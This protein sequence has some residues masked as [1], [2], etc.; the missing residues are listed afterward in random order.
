[1]ST[2]APAVGR[3]TTGL[4][5]DV[6]DVL[7]SHGYERAPGRTLSASLP[8]LDDLLGELAATYEGRATEEVAGA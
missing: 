6:F 4:L 1:M 7:A 8:L 3:P 2:P 5:A